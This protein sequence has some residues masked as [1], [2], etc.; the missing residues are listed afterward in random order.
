MTNSW[1][2]GHLSKGQVASLLSRCQCCHFQC[3]FALQGLPAASCNFPTAHLCSF[4]LC[5]APPWFSWLSCHQECWSW[6]L[7]LAGERG[8]AV[9]PGCQF[10][11]ATAPLG[12]ATP[13]HSPFS[14]GPQSHIITSSQQ[15]VPQR[16]HRE[17]DREKKGQGE[18]DGL[19]D[20]MP[21]TSS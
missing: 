19:A 15:H 5:W 21:T 16:H 18:E 20:I 4:W 14:T 3:S 7:H 9:L 2:L 1:R 10:R 13:C 12:S 8:K 17:G 11:T 6:S